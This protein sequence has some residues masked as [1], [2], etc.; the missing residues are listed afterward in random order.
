MMYPF[1]TLEDDTEITH[2]EMLEDGS[3]KV[4]I[5]T[6]DEADGFHDATCFLPAHR[7]E[8]VHGYS[9]EELERLKQLVRNNAHLIM[10]FSRKGGVLQSGEGNI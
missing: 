8:E 1:L 10:E 9:Q 4:Y 5:E 6:P 3:V 7:W 2:S